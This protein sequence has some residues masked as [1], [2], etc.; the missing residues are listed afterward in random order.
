MGI[1]LSEYQPMGQNKALEN[2]LYWNAQ[3]ANMDSDANI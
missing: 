3:S 1:P 2:F